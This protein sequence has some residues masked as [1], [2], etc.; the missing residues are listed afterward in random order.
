MFLSGLYFGH[1]HSIFDTALEALTLHFSYC[2]T[3]LSSYKRLPNFC[4]LD[5]QSRHFYLYLISVGRLVEKPSQIRLIHRNKVQFL[6]RI[7]LM[8]LIHFFPRGEIKL[9]PI[10]TY[11]Y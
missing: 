4:C 8:D 2:Q 5:A 3:T 10:Y 1:N 6:Y 11:K 9:C 7:L